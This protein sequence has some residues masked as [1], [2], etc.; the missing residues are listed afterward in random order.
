[1][2]NPDLAKVEIGSRLE[3]YWEVD[4]KYYEATVSRERK[5]SAMPWYLEYDNGDC[6]W[7]DLRQHQFRLRSKPLRKNCS[8]QKLSRQLMVTPDLAKV[9]IGSRLAVY[10]EVDGKYFEATVL[11]RRDMSMTWYL[12]YDNGDR[13]WIDL[14]PHKFRLLPRGSSR[15]I[16]DEIDDD[17]NWL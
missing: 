11:R 1:V 8:S 6:E 4:G 3:V 2:V 9:E 14:G 5:T 12:E 17:D 16:V 10:W 13:E 7:I 15:R